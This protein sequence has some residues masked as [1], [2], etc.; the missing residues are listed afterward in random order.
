MLNATSVTTKGVPNKWIYDLLYR[1]ILPNVRVV[2]INEKK[3][4]QPAA[5]SNNAMDGQQRP[6]SRKK[7]KKKPEDS[8]CLKCTNSIHGRILTLNDEKF[9]NASSEDPSPRMMIRYD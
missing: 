5:R 1:P 3:P 6:R 7:T 9:I 4:Q 8:R 2:L